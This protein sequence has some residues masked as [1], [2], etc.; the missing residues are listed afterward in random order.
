MSKFPDFTFDLKLAELNEVPES[1]CRN[2][3]FNY[4]PPNGSEI[5]HNDLYG[6]HDTCNGEFRTRDISHAPADLGGGG[7]VHAFL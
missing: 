6:N 5:C 2:L 1:V 7:V 4:H 3:F